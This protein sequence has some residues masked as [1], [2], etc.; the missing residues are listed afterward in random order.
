MLPSLGLCLSALGHP[1]NTFRN[2]HDGFGSDGLLHLKQ[3]IPQHVM[4]TTTHLVDMCAI[5]ISCHGA[6]WRTSIVQPRRGATGCPTRFVLGVRL[7]HLLA[8]HTDSDHAVG[9][10]RVRQRSSALRCPT[11]PL[12]TFRLRPQHCPIYR[13]PQIPMP[14][15]IGCHPHSSHRCRSTAF[16][17]VVLLLERQNNVTCHAGPG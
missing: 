8:P 13:S 2:S 11:S 16:E 6:N 1:Q 5:L 3:L 17:V 12:S 4:I 7:E 10:P 14:P 15:P 9:P